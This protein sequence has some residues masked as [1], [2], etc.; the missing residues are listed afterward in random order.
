MA[1]LITASLP[2]FNSSRRESSL[3]TWG[4]LGLLSLLLCLCLSSE[5]DRQ[6]GPPAPL[7]MQL[8]GEIDTR[9]MA[10]GGGGRATQSIREERGV[11][12]AEYGFINF[13][14]DPLQIRF[15]LPA[16]DLAAYRLGYG[17]TQADL[18]AI[19]AW[20]KRALAEAYDQAVKNSW[21][22]E[23]LNSVSRTIQQEFR[24]KQE[25][26][27]AS[28]G[29]RLQ[30][31]KTLV[32]DIPAIVRRNIKPLNDVAR[33]FHQVAATQGY[34]S[35]E[36]IASV[37][38]MVQTALHYKD[39]PASQGGRVIGGITPP[40]VT[41]VAGEGDCDAKTALMAAILR[42]WSHIKLIGVGVPNHYL[43]GVLQNP[44]K[45]QL[46]VE[47]EGM[48]YVLLEPAGPG[49]LPPG[50]LAESTVGLLSS[51]ENLRMEAL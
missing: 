26:L 45:G 1:P 13:N 36:T 21:G 23:R 22:Q 39:L 15:S 40:L 32:P 38:S 25:E 43:L 50:T 44:A 4:I 37:L 11:I 47:Y 20:Q 18:D 7:T 46:Y 28:R 19:M 51:G 48:L 41:M 42:N 8:A 10:A 34:D 5:K 12:S 3:F 14:N 2:L 35:Q 17:Y 49:W 9:A 30:Q 33:Q 24:S 27:F 31:G 29:F 6:S 16:S